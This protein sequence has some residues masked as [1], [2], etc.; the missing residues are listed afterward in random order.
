MRNRI[1]ANLISL[2]VLLC[3][4]GAAYG[5]GAP[6]IFVTGRLSNLAGEPLIGPV[7]IVLKLYT[8]QAATQALWSETHNGVALSGGRFDLLMGS[9]TA[10]P[11]ADSFA[12]PGSLWLGVSVNGEGE[13]PRSPLSSVAYAMQ[14]SSAVTAKSLTGPAGD[15]ECTGCVG[16]GDLALGTVGR[17]HMDPNTCA[18]GQ[19]LRT[20]TQSKTWI[21]SKDTLEATV[22]P[23]GQLLHYAGNAWRCGD[24]RVLSSDEVDTINGA[25]GYANHDEL[26]PVATEGTFQ[27][28]DLIPEGLLDG[29]NDALGVLT[30]LEN[31]MPK[32][33]G[34]KWT[35]TDSFSIYQGGTGVSITDATIDLRADDCEAGW[36]LRRNATND[37]WVCSP[38]LQAG[39]GLD[40]TDGVVTLDRD[41]MSANFVMNGTFE[42]IP[43]GML[44]A[45]AVSDTN[46]QSVGWSK[47]INVPAG[48]ADGVDDGLT[49]ESDPQVGTVYKDKW[50]TSDG[51]MINC[52]SENPITAETDPQVGDNTAGYLA[53]WNGLAL[54]ASK[55]IQNA[56]SVGIGVATPAGALQVGG[57][58]VRV[59]STGTPTLATGDGALFVAGKV[60]VDGEARFDGKV[61]TVGQA[62]FQDT[63]SFTGLATFTGG[64]KLGAN[65]DMG[66]KKIAFLSNPTDTTDAATK[67]YVDQTAT[68]AVANSP[69][70]ANMRSIY[71]VVLGV[72]DPSYCPTGFTADQVSKLAGPNGSV[73]VDISSNGLF[74]GGVDSATSTRTMQATVSGSV[75]YLCS[76]TYESGSGRPFAAI[77][78]F[79][80]GSAASCKEGFFHLPVSQ[81]SGNGSLMATRYGLFIGNA[82]NWAYAAASNYSQGGYV[83]RTWQG[84]V[85]SEVDNIC[86]RIMGVDSDSFAPQG[87]YPVFLGLRNAANCPTGWNSS[88]ITA[89]DGSDAYWHLQATDSASVMGGLFQSYQGGA[90]SLYVKANSTVTT[91]ICWKYMA[92]KGAPNFQIRTPGTGTCPTGFTA[93]AHDQLKALTNNLGYIVSNRFALYLGPVL[94]KALVEQGNS[95]TEFTFGAQAV[96][97]FCLAFNDLK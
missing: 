8:S 77:E 72:Q 45:G 15:L 57:A 38:E 1:L 90:S 21:C 13:L 30:C 97:T 82:T 56:T 79:K 46:V 36:H 37:Q 92:V 24:D 62:A 85:G 39:D 10:L 63:S 93:F 88:A 64:A 12:E 52:A 14:A 67:T 20:S 32:Y 31:Q 83:A 2:A 9:I 34:A 42:A 47:L 91:A 59:G 26:A 17:Q 75:A 60:E 69:G 19:F 74:M 61:T 70:L 23:D 41:Y 58:E 3:A 44:Q 27:S 7:R 53:Y 51:T 49:K 50:C 96:N 80:G 84:G 94:D 66:G 95:T 4:A 76:R 81:I 65:L 68:A 5:A 22:C 43:P 71:T 48:F 29:D 33:D 16:S 35:C 28:L 89:L 86:V 87:V 11:Q 18:A 6:Q 54:V 78:M 55:I 25:L 40:V 73:T